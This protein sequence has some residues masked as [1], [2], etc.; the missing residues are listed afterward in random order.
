MT[1][2]KNLLADLEAL[3]ER[4]VGGRECV[5]GTAILALPN[6]VQ[7]QVLRAIGNPRYALRTLS[8]VLEKNGIPTSEST[9]RKH[10]Q[11]MC[12]WCREHNLAALT[13]E[14]V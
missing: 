2:T 13:P 10:R 9:V 5:L 1:D 8:S 4:G 12:R 6:E 3:P 14:A 11:G 7:V